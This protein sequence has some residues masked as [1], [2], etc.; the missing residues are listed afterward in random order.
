MWSKI[1]YC[2]VQK[3][4]F[5]HIEHLE[6]WDFENQTLSLQTYPIKQGIYNTLPS[7]AIKL[8]GDVYFIN[9]SMISFI[10]II[11]S[12]LS[13]YN[14]S[15]MN[16]RGLFQDRLLVIV[17]QPEFFIRIEIA[18]RGVLENLK[19]SGDR[20]PGRIV[21][22]DRLALCQVDIPPFCIPPTI[23]HL[24]RTKPECQTAAR[25]CKRTPFF[26]VGH[27]DIQTAEKINY[28]GNRAHYNLS[29][30]VHHKIIL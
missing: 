25:V 18:T 30:R 20:Y 5:S 16:C 11:S 23:W 2:S 24:N 17:S 1:L 19:T 26:L 4:I 22:N 29:N 15:N 9:L 12:S 28:P 10:I 8:R 14:C 3:G 6:H 7:S 13:M 27:F 21:Q